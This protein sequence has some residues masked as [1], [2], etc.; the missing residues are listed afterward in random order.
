MKIYRNFFDKTPEIFLLI[1]TV[2][3][4]FSF[5]SIKPAYAGEESETKEPE[6]EKSKT[7]YGCEIDF[8]S[9]YVWRGIPFSKGSVM[10]PYLWVTSRGFTYSLWGNMPLA[11][12]SLN[13]GKFDEI[14]PCISYSFN[15]GKLELE[16]RVQM[17]L[18]PDGADNTGEAAV[19]A[20][21]PC[22]DFKAIM[23]HGFDINKYKGAYYGE[24]GIAY[25]KELTPKL[26][27]KASSCAGFATSKF[28]EAYA[29]IPVRGLY[30]VNNSLCATY[31]PSAD[32]PLYFRPHIEFSTITNNRLRRFL[33][34]PDQCTW[35]L[36]VGTEF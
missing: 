35:G 36:V 26:S 8:N 1:L 18:Y 14:D 5:S 27:L 17:Y 11:K 7:T 20:S 12:G 3:F 10:Q 16:P 15:V 29:G 28:T 33:D 9:R 34:T 2:M 32:G 30:V 25:E 22:G 13:R 19:A 31:Y 6:D 4:F 24:A 23:F 21:Y